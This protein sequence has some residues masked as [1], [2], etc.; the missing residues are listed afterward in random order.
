MNVSFFQ[1]LL[2]AISDRG[3]QLL[4]LSG[5]TAPQTETIETLC[6]A[7]LSS[8]GEASGVALA[9]QILARYAALDMDGRRAFFRFLADGFGPDAEALNR[10]VRLYI[11]E[12]GPEALKRLAHAV[13]SPRAEFLRRLNLAPG[14]T[15]DIVNMRADL[16]G[17][18]K[19]DAGLAAVDADFVHLLVPWFNR[20]FLVLQGID[21]ATPANI[22]DKIIRY[23]ADDEIKGW[24]DLRRR[25][26]PVDRRCF[27]FFHP[28][29][30]DEP[31]IFLQA[32][33]LREMPAT[34]AEILNAPLPDARQAPEP[35]TAVFYAITDCQKGL[36]GISFGNFLMKQVV[37]TLACDI[38][39]LKTFIALSPMPGFAAWL[40]R[41]KTSNIL[42]YLDATQLAVLD[43]LDDPGWI[44]DEALAEALRPLVLSVAAHYF[45]VAKNVNARP[46]DPQARFHLANGARLE[47][48]NWMAD[49]SPKGLMESHGL[50]ASYRYDL[51]D[52]E[53]NH[54]MYANS[55]SI[56]APKPVRALLKVAEKSRA[57]V[58]ATPSAVEE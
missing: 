51:R 31:L 49:L 38:P 56:A 5:I 52:I 48:I 33:L 41:A 9:R 14:A 30:I 8:R 21:W 37:D 6:Q 3:R 39:S 15:S 2:T 43:N 42:T 24:D 28:A 55:G 35:A 16:L 13:E 11:E 29:L 58:P 1:E 46:I 26:D 44:D 23:E 45:L 53:D 12:P 47:R 32:A 19:G 57:L 20:G 7:L 36:R 22:L 17:L 54:E 25:L 10:A 50:M 4:D 34:I 27:A 18:I 40:A